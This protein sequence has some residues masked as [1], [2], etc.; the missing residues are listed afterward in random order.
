MRRALLA[1]GLV[2]LSIVASNGMRSARASVPVLVIDG[3]GFGH[4]VGMAQDGALWMGVGGANLGQILGHFYPGTAFGHAS[5]GVRVTVM[6]SDSGDAVLGFPDGGQVRDAPDGQQSAGFPV[7]VPAG[8]QARVWWDGARYHAQPVTS[9]GAYAAPVAA[10][11]DG[12]RAGI[13]LASTSTRPSAS[14]STTKP[15]ARRP[16]ADAATGAAYAPRLVTGCA[17]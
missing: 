1:A 13:G 3:H 15:P 8:G 14:T 7:D 4:G 9:R 2:G 16:S 12:R 6:K 10:S 17:W 11:A 5:G